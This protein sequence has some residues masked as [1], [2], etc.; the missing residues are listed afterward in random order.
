MAFD[1]LANNLSGGPAVIDAPGGV[2]ATE[3][4]FIDDYTYANKYQPEL[5]KDLHMAYGRGK[6]LKLTELIGNTRSYASDQMIHAEEGRLHNKLT[7]V[8]VSG[9]TFT[10]PTPHN[11]R[12]ND[13][14]LV[15][16]GVVQVQATVQSV[17]STT[18]F[19]ATK[20]DGTAFNFTDTVDI[21]VDFSNSWGKGDD[22]FDEAREW[23]PTKFY[24][25][26]HII[27]ETYKKN[28]SDRIHRTW[29]QTP[30]GPR[31]YNHEMMNTSTLFDNEVELTH[32]FHERK[33]TGRNRGMNGLVPTIET[34]GNIAN[35]YIT[36]IE[37]L[38]EI[39]RRLK[40]QG[41]ACNSYNVWHD[42]QQGAYFRQMLSG[43]N[44]AYSEGSNYG[45]F[46]N[47]KDMA[48]FL[49]FK[50]VYIDGVTFHFQSLDILEDPSLMGSD[51]FR[52]TGLAYLMVPNGNMSI[53]EGGKTVSRPFYSVGYREDE[54]Y[55]RRR[56]LKLFGPGGT[57]ISGDYS[58]WDWLSETMGQIVGANNYLV[59]RTGAFY[60]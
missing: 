55:S 33:A 24:A 25:H 34:F 54:Q 56:E 44:S 16:D 19:V 17:T 30:D 60:S 48:L 22:T 12:V 9:T 23:D 7:N 40:Q 57:A 4:N 18:V 45:A 5:L 13:T 3:A 41:G 14:I 38:S 59:G 32:I 51:K 1:L 6:I 47:S 49:G 8:A 43:V 39:V 27:K 20:D 58:K 26:T 35:E 29:I 42:H 53:T 46:D 31:W 21:M 52:A 11:A 15:T 10:S 36:D 28:N 2:L 37:E 50:S